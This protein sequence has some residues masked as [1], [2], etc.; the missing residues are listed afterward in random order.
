MYPLKPRMSRR[1]NV[2]I[3]L[4]IWTASSLLSSP[5]LVFSTT[6]TQDFKN[7]DFR[8]ICIMHWPDGQTTESSLEYV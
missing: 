3:M 4:L 1:A 8:V 6:T 7:G 5:N 2:I